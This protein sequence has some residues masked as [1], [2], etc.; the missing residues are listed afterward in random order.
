[1][2]VVQGMRRWRG[3]AGRRWEGLK[4]GEFWRGGRTWLSNGSQL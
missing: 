4:G 1:M 3:E 2:W